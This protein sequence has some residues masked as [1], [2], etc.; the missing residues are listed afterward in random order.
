MTTVVQAPLKMVESLAD[1]RLPPRADRL[2]QRLMDR[3]TEAALST[4]E[5]EELEALVELSERI[6]LVRAQALQLLGRTPQ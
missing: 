4:E 6:A 2:L 1:L 5:R 3:N